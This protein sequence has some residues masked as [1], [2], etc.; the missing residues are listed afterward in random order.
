MFLV[1]REEWH[2]AVFGP[3]KRWIGVAYRSVYPGR[4]FQGIESS[5]DRRVDLET[6]I[7][8]FRAKETSR[9]A[10]FLAQAKRSPQFSQHAFV[11]SLIPIR[12]FTTTSLTP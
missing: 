7:D 4:T 3:Q 6:V 12:S 9:A 2:S 10:L 5:T 11:R 8:S 1:T